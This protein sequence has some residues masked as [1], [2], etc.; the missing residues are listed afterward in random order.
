MTFN[1]KSNALTCQ[2]QN[3][4]PNKKQTDDIRE[5]VGMSYIDCGFIYDPQGNRKHTLFKAKGSPRHKI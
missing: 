4:F 3:Q 2:W 1:I 5:M